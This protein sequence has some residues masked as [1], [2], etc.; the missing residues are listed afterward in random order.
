MWPIAP[1][2][3]RSLGV[4][5]YGHRFTNGLAGALG[6][7]PTTIAIALHRPWPP[8]PAAGRGGPGAPRK[9]HYIRDVLDHECAR[10][11]AALVVL[12][13]A[14]IDANV[15]DATL[16]HVAR[17]LL[18][19]TYTELGE[20]IGCKR[21]SPMRI[22]RGRVRLVRG[23]RRALASAVSERIALLQRLQAGLLNRGKGDARWGS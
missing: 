10:R 21:Y 14:L 15:D 12:R 20:M 8:A 5:L 19:A 17:H 13:C 2:L 18:R 7:S 23:K 9:Q 4:A 22:A 6:A 1:E 16:I 3:L 11:I